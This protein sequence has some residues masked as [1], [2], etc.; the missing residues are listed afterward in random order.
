MYDN[1]MYVVGLA[2][3]K[4]S[5]YDPESKCNLFMNHKVFGF[6]TEPTANIMK[7]LKTGTLVDLKG[8]ITDN[9]SASATSDEILGILKQLIQTLSEHDIDGI[10]DMLR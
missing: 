7:A 9:V 10:L 1:Y 4:L 3:G 5:F 8:T 6:N 2:P